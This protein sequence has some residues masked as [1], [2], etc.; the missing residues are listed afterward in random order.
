MMI[1]RMRARYF[2]MVIFPLIR[3]S[4]SRSLQG[5]QTAMPS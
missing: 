2:I 3:M 4:V 1:E 5:A